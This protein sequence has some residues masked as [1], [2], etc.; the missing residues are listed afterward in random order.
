MKNEVYYVPVKRILA[1]INSCHTNEQIQNCKK[2]VNDY[3]KAV[4]KQGVS[5]S[6][7]LKDRLYA[8]LEQREE[9]LYLAEM[10]N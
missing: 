9:A 7:D 4:T 5:N 1:I 3:I 10:L 2:I 6:S 8:E